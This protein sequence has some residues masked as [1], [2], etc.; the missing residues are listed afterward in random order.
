MQLKEKSEKTMF[1]PARIEREA[2]G[3]ME[4][5]TVLGNVS[6]AVTLMEFLRAN[7]ISDRKQFEIFLERT[8]YAVCNR[9][10]QT[11]L[12]SS[13]FKDAL[14]M[15]VEKDI[16]EYILSEFHSGNAISFD[17]MCANLYMVPPCVSFSLSK[18]IYYS[19]NESSV[20]CQSN[21]LFKLVADVDWLKD[22]LHTAEELLSEIKYINIAKEKGAPANAGKEYEQHKNA[23]KFIHNQKNIF[24]SKWNEELF[25]HKGSGIKLFSLYEMPNFQINGRKGQD[26]D[27]VFANFLSGCDKRIMIVLGNPG[28]GKSSLMSY[29]ANKYQE[30]DHYIFIKMFELEP[31]K[32]NESLLHAVTDFLECRKRDLYNTVLFL[33]GYDELRVDNRH[34]ELCLKLISEIYS[35]PGLKVVMSSRLNY[36]D[37]DKNK[38]ERDFHCA[39]TVVLMPFIKNQMIGFIEKYDRAIGNKDKGKIMQF[40]NIS[41]EKEIFGIPF[42]LYLI[43][44]LNLN[45]ENVQNIFDLYEKVFAFNDG[46]YD[47][48]YDKNAG[49][50]LTRNPQNKRELLLVSKLFALE[51]FRNKSG[52][53][54]SKA[55]A[56]RIL[57]KDCP[58][59]KNDFAIGNYYNIE[60][61]R[62]MFVH[63][64]FG[65]YF[66]T[67]YIIDFLEEILD[68][69][70]EQI[71]LKLWDI[72]QQNYMYKRLENLLELAITENVKLTDAHFIERM[73]ECCQYVLSHF[74]L[75]PVSGTSIE[76]YYL[77][78]QNYL[79]SVCK[80]FKL[81]I[82]KNWVRF[83]KGGSAFWSFL[84]RNKGYCKI[85]LE[86]LHL[87][88]ADISGSVLRGNLTFSEFNFCN[89]CRVD[90]HKCNAEKSVWA[91]CDIILAYAVRLKLNNIKC[92][93][94]AFDLS[95]LGKAEFSHADIANVS[96]ESIFG[97]GILFIDS[98][99]AHSSFFRAD[100]ENAE[101]VNSSLSDV[102]FKGAILRKANFRKAKMNKVDF[103]DADLSNADFRG[104]EFQEVIFDGAKMDGA[105]FDK[106]GIM[107]L[108]QAK[109]RFDPNI[110]IEK[111]IGRRLVTYEEYI[112][113]TKNAR[114]KQSNQNQISHEQ[115]DTQF[116][117]ECGF[118]DEQ[119]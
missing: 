97:Y 86:N 104:A 35:V 69:S 92:K 4:I 88:Q 108:V 84:V 91:N 29:W 6:S 67:K 70:N 12:M 42:I 78:L 45:I 11:L 74:E 39:D 3:Y 116:L 32:A 94:C 36:I 115:E 100:L 50:Y 51:M 112:N 52:I 31:D 23:L 87:E 71:M 57:S 113:V 1:R 105:I 93:N 48:I 25:L 65:E 82:G 63:R 16:I 5:P 73:E 60:A 18:E 119:D 95:N 106:N 10:R 96:F 26:L 79:T 64:T 24:I 109:T 54:I 37:L 53:E 58:N 56:D 101:Y 8:V 62:I 7:F 2:S 33:D 102:K 40:S 49:H 46:I 44:A 66:F 14:P 90:F 13:E 76:D 77:R 28:L 22:H 117:R 61:N 55:T 20:F 47:K 83:V 75:L 118:G 43:C 107:W 72:F 99:I 17:N 15:N 59:R 85:D 98:Q 111:R 19:L 89:M 80:I 30:A 103:S 81:T 21:S 110:L 38:F 27:E 34:Y 41:T 9:M 114:K 68:L